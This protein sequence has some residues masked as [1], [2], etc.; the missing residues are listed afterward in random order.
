MHLASTLLIRLSLLLPSNVR[1]LL[2]SND[3]ISSALHLS[4]LSPPRQT[5]PLSANLTI[6]LGKIKHLS[7]T[8]LP[9]SLAT[10]LCQTSLFLFSLSSRQP[11]SPPHPTLLLPLIV[12][13]ASHPPFSD[14]AGKCHPRSLPWRHSHQLLQLALS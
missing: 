1:L 11:S 9:P 4:H 10:Q 3:G 7:K 6:L 8:C 2:S 12:L 5:S 13:K 14:V